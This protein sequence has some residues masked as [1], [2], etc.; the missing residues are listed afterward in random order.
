[1]KQL[2]FTLL[3]LS[4]LLA[5]GYSQVMSLKQCIDSAIQNNYN[6]RIAG[7]EVL[8]AQEKIAEAKG[9][10]LPKI[11]TAIDYRYY[12]NLPYQLLPAAVFGGPA[13]TY[14][15]AQFGVP[16][17]I[18]ANVQ[19]TYPLYNPVIQANIKTIQTGEEMAGLQKIKSQ[20][21][22]AMEVSNI[23]YN[24]QVLINQL[25]FIDS[26]IVNSRKLLSVMDLLYQQ[27]MAKGTDVEKINLQLAQL[28]TQ[29]ETV[30]SQY[31]Q[32]MN[33]LK[34]LI[35]KSQ[36][37]TIS[38]EANRRSNEYPVID[39]NPLTEIK[40]VEKQVSFLQTE[41]YAM[42][43]S[44]LPAINLNGLYGTTGFGANGSNSFLKLYPLG[45]AGI[46][47]IMPIY[48]GNLTR[49]KIKGKEL[50]IEKTGIKLQMVREKYKVDKLNNTY[51]LNIIH[52]SL[53]TIQQQV[54]LA[55]TIYAKTILQQKEGIATITDVLLADNA[56]REAQQNYI[57]SLIALS[58]AEIEFK[59]LT[60]NLLN[61]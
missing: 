58:R 14:K 19:L 35:G 39:D 29:K 10:L 11:N 2:L 57:A 4:L 54:K 46:Q 22:I 12:T 24:A 37:G 50:E 59:K 52:K 38:I 60:G 25:G 48:T 21:E 56:V 34:F 41:K 7:Y 49:Q 1:M 31:S 55:Q 33:I 32:V 40:L 9:N 43:K 26:N 28:L 27:Q 36:D 17:N 23:Y 13:G 18:N 16:H 30:E 61:K 42:Q 44:R 5:P 51:Q 20:E 53:I 47:V 6:A 8:Q 15:E 3:L 45:Y